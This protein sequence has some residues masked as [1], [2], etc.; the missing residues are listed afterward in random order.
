MNS[1]KK[2]LTLLL[3]ASALVLLSACAPQVQDSA[4]KALDSAGTVIQPGLQK[5]WEPTPGA[6]PL[7]TEPESKKVK[8]QPQQL[9]EIIAPVRSSVRWGHPVLGFSDIQIY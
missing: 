7:L 4:G 5:V 8:A 9:T 1:T 3:M 2:N 6:P